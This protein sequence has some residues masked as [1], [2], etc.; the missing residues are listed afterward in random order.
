MGWPTILTVLAAA[1]SAGVA[2][3][4]WCG[5]D[6]D[7]DDFQYGWIW[8]WTTLFAFVGLLPIAAML[9]GEI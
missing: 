1:A 7:L 5:R 3:A 2:A 6:G 8:L 4:W 9:T